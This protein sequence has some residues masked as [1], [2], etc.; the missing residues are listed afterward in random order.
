MNRY[1]IPIL[2]VLI[3]SGVYIKYIDPS[4]QEVAML[5]GKYADLESH[6]LDA[7]KAKEIIDKLEETSKKF[8]PDYEQQEKYCS[9]Q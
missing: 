6:K 1:I 9:V 2:L 7:D 4:Y 8:P 5:Q 3:S